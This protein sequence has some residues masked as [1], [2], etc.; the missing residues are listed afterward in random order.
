MAQERSK[1]WKASLPYILS[2]HKVRHTTINV[3][4]GWETLSQVV[5]VLADEMVV[6]ISPDSKKKR[7][8]ATGVTE[9]VARREKSTY[10]STS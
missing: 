8:D 6:K 3:A 5:T 2:P 7:E 9:T 4:K 10:C 1:Q